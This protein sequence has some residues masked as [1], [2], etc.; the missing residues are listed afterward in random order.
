MNKFELTVSSFLLGINFGE[1]SSDSKSASAIAI[2]KND[3][4]YLTQLE[5]IC[6]QL[7]TQ[8]FPMLH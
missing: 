3:N 7:T 1:G 2:D 8:H 4:F 5:E 6:L